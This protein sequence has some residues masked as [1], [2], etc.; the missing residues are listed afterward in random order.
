MGQ[1]ATKSVLKR[2][3]IKAQNKEKNELYVDEIAEKPFNDDVRSSSINLQLEKLNAMEC[4][5]VSEI[6]N[7]KTI[8][9]EY[10][11]V[12]QSGYKHD[13][14]LLKQC[15]AVTKPKIFVY[16]NSSSKF[17]RKNGF[18]NMTRNKLLTVCVQN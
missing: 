8:K 6:P 4:D 5:K 11:E 17:Q 9:S 14:E 16:T 18:Q 1:C 13:M 3:K 2:R 12:L 15:S 7:S 10:Y